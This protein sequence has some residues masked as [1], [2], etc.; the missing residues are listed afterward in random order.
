[1]ANKN[2][3]VRNGI[4]APL[5]AS[6]SGV[7]AI[8][9]SGDDV[10]TVGDLAVGS[11]FINAGNGTR[12]I[13][14]TDLGSVQIQL[15]LKLNG[16]QI[17]SSGTTS[18]G[19]IRYNNSTDKWQQSR[20]FGGTWADIPVNTSELAEL[21]NLYYTDV[22]ARAALSGGTGVSYDNLTGVISI[23]QAV[24]TTDNVTFGTVDTTSLDVTNIRALDG[25]AA[26][27][28]AN[29]TGA[30]TISSSLQV[31]DINISGNTISSTD[32]FTSTGSSISGNTLTIGTLTAGTIEIGQTISGGTTLGSTIITANI[33]GTGSG[34]T[35]TVSG[36]A[37][38]VA[39]AALNGSGNISLTP[40]GVG[41]V[42]MPTAS[43][44]K[45]IAAGNAAIGGSGEIGAPAAFDATGAAT[46]ST[47]QLGVRSENV[48]SGFAVTNSVI[49]HGQ[50]RP[51][52]TATTGGNPNIFLE[53]TRGT[54]AAPTATGANDIL[55]AISLAGHDGVR[56]LGSQVNGGSVQLVA[57]AGQAFL[58]NGTYTT[59]AGATTILRSQP[60]NLRLH[61][62]SRQNLF[63]A[64]YTGGTTNTPPTQ[65][66]IFNSS[67]MT[68]QYDA[69]GNSIN[70]HGR[71]DLIFYHPTFTIFGVP[72]Q[73]TANTDNTTLPG[74]N[75][76]NFNT[77]RQSGWS[78]RRDPVELNDTLAE[79]R[80]F[81]QTG[82]NSTGTGS[83]TGTLSWTASENFTTSVRGS[84]FAVQTGEIG[85]NTLSDRITID[86]VSGAISTVKTAQRAP[87]G[88]TTY[89]GEISQKVGVRNGAGAYDRATELSVTSITTDG[90]S[91]ATYE[92]KTNRYDG[93][94]YA[95]TVS[96]DTLGRFTFLGNYG[97]STTPL[98]VNAAGALQVRAAETF[99][100]TASGTSLSFSVNKLG[101]NTGLDALE[102]SSAQA[103]IRGDAVVLQDSSLAALKGGK[104]QY[105]RTYGCFH[106]MADVTA[107]AADTVYEFDWTTDVTPHVNTQGVTVSNTSRLNIDT[108]GVYNV[109]LE[110]QAQNTD[111]ADR[112]AYVW[113]AKNGT[114][115]DETCIRVV[116]T[117]DTSTV[118]TKDWLI[119]GITAGQYIE[120]RFAVDNPSGIS[121][122]YSPLQTTP[123]ARP[124]IASATITIEAMGA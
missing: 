4:E 53:S 104:I 1:M 18:Q 75:R 26:A 31:D 7:T 85:T 28:I 10:K 116:L 95:A 11:N 51:G 73:S 59:Q 80:V 94:N 87:G 83:Q 17:L 22:R 74:T 69:A 120:V 118:I 117:K 24:G 43:V 55:G 39:S 41:N 119:D 46:G 110:M 15:D 14:L 100:A 121:L 34:S 58:N 107:L 57:L 50:N 71:Q 108:E 44:A 48:T 3:K 109:I 8:T 64:N 111:N 76:I 98:S 102:V 56:G 23:G 124:A 36:P 89:G 30:V 37:Q 122:Q 33:S 12:A 86:S 65:N 91:A 96:G 70:G 97:T 29:T 21:T 5:I 123:Y 9:L 77:S 78:T 38:T 52:G 82:T 40:I 67:T 84:K 79:I 63:L 114:D 32:S 45:S 27:T 93:T 25:T 47:M 115:L 35:W 66:L 106:K 72:S 54:A 61:S 105:R 81:G 92:T 20:N 19:R 99:T 42:I 90:S 88:N 68:T 49:D 113:L 60:N 16:D 2:F 101:T 6:E 13:T 103:S 62:T 112:T